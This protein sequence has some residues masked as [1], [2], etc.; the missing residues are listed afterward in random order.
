MTLENEPLEA[1][2]KSLEHVPLADF[3]KQGR[4]L[5]EGFGYF[6]DETS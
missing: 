4:E 2:R 5:L 1:L 3:E 6:Q